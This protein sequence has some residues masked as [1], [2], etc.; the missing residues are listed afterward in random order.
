MTHQNINK[1]SPTENISLPKRHIAF[2][3]P[4]IPREPLPR[5]TR[6]P[7]PYPKDFQRFQ[8]SLNNQLRRNRDANSQILNLNLDAGQSPSQSQIK[9]AVVTPMKNDINGD[10]LQHH[11]STQTDFISPPDNHPPNY[12][13]D[14]L[15]YNHN[16][17]TNSAVN[18]NNSD[19]YSYND[20][21]SVNSLDGLDHDDKL[22][23]DMQE[24][25]MMVTAKQP[26]PYHIAAAYSKNAKYFNK[27]E[28]Y[29]E[30]DK[31]KKFTQDLQAQNIPVP[32]PVNYS[33]KTDGLLQE[34]NKRIDDHYANQNYEKNYV[35]E[36]QFAENLN[37]ES[38]V[39][40]NLTVVLTP[41][42]YVLGFTVTYNES[43]S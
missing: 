24:K 17:N 35:V 39:P 33:K 12:E 5:L 14:F 25:C 41:C 1:E 15:N 42:C 3:E 8:R 13:N 7:T 34:I 32:Q 43:V 29:M 19:H 30:D 40:K 20:K 26:P 9:E 37:N 27:V 18:D 38:R 28:D 11:F 16:S 21:N 36:K 22:S 10:H 4:G 6:A 2:T 31:P 23:V